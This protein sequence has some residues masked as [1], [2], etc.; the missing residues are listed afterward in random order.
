MPGPE[1]VPL[2]GLLIESRYFFSVKVAVTPFMLP[3]VTLHG[4]VPLHAPD[5]PPKSELPSAVAL[6][7]TMVPLSYNAAHAGP[8][9]IEPR[10]DTTVPP[11]LPALPTI[12]WYFL[13][14]NLAVTELITPTWTG[15]AAVPLQGP[16]Q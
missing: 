5:Q 8:Q 12:S 11:P 16:D 10:S 3:M 13:S 4:P 7:V 14:T 6:N 2:P 9:L 1:T 15:Q